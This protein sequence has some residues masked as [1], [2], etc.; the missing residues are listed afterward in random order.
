MTHSDSISRS[1]IQRIESYLQKGDLDKI[2]RIIDRVDYH[3]VAK[4]LNLSRRKQ[5]IFELLKPEMQAAVM[6]LLSE[7]V[8][9]ALLKD[10]PE[11]ELKNWYE[12][13][14]PV[15]SDAVISALPTEISDT[16]AHEFELAQ[17]KRMEAFLPEHP[18]SAGEIMTSNF[19][20]ARSNSLVKDVAKKI[21]DYLGGHTEIPV[22]LATDESG[23]VTGRVYLALLIKSEESTPISKIIQNVPTVSSSINQDELLTIIRKHPKDDLVV[24]VD[25][26]ERPIGV[27]HAR[28]LLNVMETS[29]TEDFY[30]FAGVY[31]EEQAIEPI[32]R[33]VVMRYR[34]LL[35]NLLTA[36]LAASVVNFFEGTLQKMV[37]LAVYMPVIACMGGN[38][39][40]QTLAVVVRG[41]SLDQIPHG[42]GRIVLLKESVAALINGC[43]VGIAVGVVAWMLHG[44]FG[45]AYVLMLSMIIALFTAGFCGTLIPM[46]L[47]K[48]GFD[49]AISSSIFLTTFTDIV[50]FMTFLGLAT[51]FLL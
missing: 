29:V 30:N 46:G 49:P 38:A 41:L 24:A 17:T 9:K 12:T 36:L 27:V 7:R 16:T 3:E 40:T 25:D 51:W 6:P 42:S 50:G 34:W 39:G 4:L 45:L 35:L 13:M 5:A 47:R 23:K 1:D 33:T 20:V 19:I 11:N 10:V 28:D 31:G 14:D 32:G 37:L 2:H 43:I 26:H 22:V 48:L 21:E 44:D 8:R 15:E 18:E